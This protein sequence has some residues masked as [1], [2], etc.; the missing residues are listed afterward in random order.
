MKSTIFSILIF[1]SASSGYGQ[2]NS[3]NNLTPLFSTRADV[4]RILGSPKE[5]KYFCCRYETP[6]ERISVTYAIGKCK[7]GWNVQKDTILSLTVSLN[8]DIGKSFE[9][10]KLDKNKFSLSADDAFYGNWTNA[11]QGLQYSFSNIERE[12]QSITYLP[13]KSDNNLRCSSV[14]PFLPEG[15]HYPYEKISFQ[16]RSL[17]KK[18]NLFRIY[19]LLDNF[20]T[21]TIESRNNHKG[22]VLVYFDD[23]LSLKEYKLRLNKIKDFIFKSRKISAKWITVIEGGM[24]EEAEVEFYILPKGWKSPAPNPTLPSP[25]FR[26]RQ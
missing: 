20:I 13:K 10:L 9:D 26:S 16:N 12:L 18:D 17:S 11:E 24:K 6:K 14:P 7:E 3:W 5:D 15:R 25:Q 21:Q 2:T 19:A 4:E 1:I 8:S 23:K 22:Y